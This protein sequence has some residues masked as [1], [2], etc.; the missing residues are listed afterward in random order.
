MDIKIRSL[1][2]SEEECIYN[3][4]AYLF[5]EMYKYM[6]QVGLVQKIIPEGERLWIN[7]IKKSLG[8]LNMIVIASH[9]E[10][11]VGF[12]AGNLRLLPN[13][14]GS[15]KVGYISHVYITDEYK[16]Q[17]VGKKLVLELEK[18]FEE[19]SVAFVELEVLEG[20]EVAYKF[21]KKENFITDSIRMIKK[22]EKN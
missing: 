14:L 19:K 18:W 11:V 7:A 12:A 3:R 2:S 10:K 22:Y 9:E 4:V 1:T 5:C 17:G 13:Y 16:N 15:K 8:K 21:W 20:N 6:D